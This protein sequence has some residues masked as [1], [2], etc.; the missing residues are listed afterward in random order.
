[1]KNRDR[2]YSI[3]RMRSVSATSFL[4]FVLIGA[5]PV[6]HARYSVGQVWSY[7]TRR[8]D[9]FSLLRINKIQLESRAGPLPIYHISVVGV[10]LGS[11]AKPGAIDHL[12]VSRE[13]LDASVVHLVTSSG[14][15]PDSATGIT[16]WQAA[17]GGVFTIPVAEIVE[18]VD[19]SQLKSRGH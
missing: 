18:I 19:K 3:I 13:A 17:N 11:S 8:E 4:A 9:P 12:P 14:N 2:V 7:H 16:L 10:H 6:P 1:M 5:A 15:F